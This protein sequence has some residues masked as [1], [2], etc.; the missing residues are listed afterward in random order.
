M[1][2]S[3]RSVQEINKRLDE[4]NK[5]LLQNASMQ[6]QGPS[7]G[8]ANLKALEDRIAVLERTLAEMAEKHPSALMNRRIRALE[9]QING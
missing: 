8:G 6:F 1:N 9:K 2:M 3:Q 4:I 5:L 7:S